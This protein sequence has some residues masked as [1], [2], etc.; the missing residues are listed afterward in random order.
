MVSPSVTVYVVVGGDS[1]TDSGPT[2]INEY[3]EE[4][5]V[6]ELSHCGRFNI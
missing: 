1:V 3:N 5:K 4:H 6:G 2:K